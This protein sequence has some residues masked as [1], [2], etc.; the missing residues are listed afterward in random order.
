MKKFNIAYEITPILD[1]NGLTGSKSGI[2]RSMVNQIKSLSDFLIK[3]SLPN[4]IYLFTFNEFL[5]PFFDLITEFNNQ[6]NIYFIKINK[7]PSKDIDEIIDINEKINL[8]LYFK[9]DFIK[10]NP[11][12]YLIKKLIGKAQ[13]IKDKIKEKRDSYRYLESLEKELERNNIKIIHH[14]ETGFYYFK[15][16]KNIITFHDFT[17]I[18]YPYFHQEETKRI[19]KRKI[20]FSK[21]YID[22]IITV[23]NSIKKEAIKYFPNKKIISIYNIID[24]N[25]INKKNPASIKEINSQLNIEL[26]KENY[27]LFY[28]TYEPRKN[29]INLVKAFINYYQ[30]QN[31]KSKVIKLV[32]AGGEGWLSIKEKIKT[33]IIDTFNSYKKSPIIILDYLSD[34]YLY[35]LIKNAIA[36]INPSFQEGFGYQIVEAHC[37][38]TPVICSNIDIFKEISYHK[39]TIFIDPHS[40]DKEI[41]KII[42]NKE[43]ILKLKKINIEKEYFEKFSPFKIGE[44]LFNFYNSLI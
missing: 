11:F 26:E 32:L 34:C 6:K 30:N 21:N 3:K 13:Q 19:F 10:K 25:K 38:N 9:R 22:T 39:K 44:K 35:S 23:S 40:L 27:F 1:A 5:N 17:P 31:K 20:Y 15:K 24:L 14:S 7:R 43:K 42:K 36:I 2:Y 4:K 18:D 12:I 37:L 41:S 33:L 8:D 16:M 29:I 28:G